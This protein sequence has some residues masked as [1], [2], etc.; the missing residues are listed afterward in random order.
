[1][2][3]RTS[4]EELGGIGK[5]YAKK[6]QNLGIEKVEDFIFYFP[7]RY[8]DY[9]NIANIVN[10]KPGEA[11]TLKGSVWQIVNRK[12]RNRR[13]IITE[14]VISDGTGTMKI[15][16]FNQP[17][18]KTSIK[19]GNEIVVAGKVELNFNQI[20]MTSPS[21]EKF[22]DDLKHSGRIVPVYPETEGVTSK[23]L[24]YQI[25][26]LLKLVYN[27]KDYLP[28]NVKEKY[29][30]ADLP[31]ALRA[32]HFP[33]NRLDLLEA[34]KRLGFDELFP[35]LLY[36]VKQKNGMTKEKA[37]PI[38]F[39]ET[40]AKEFV[41]SLPFALTNAQKKVSWEIVKDIKKDYPANRLVQGDVG[42][43]KTIV[44]A[45]AMY[46]AAEDG[47]QAIL[48]APTEIL[49]KQHF[50][51]LCKVF[52]PFNISVGLLTGKEAQISKQLT[53]NSKQ[54]R[55]KNGHPELVSGSHGIPGQARNDNMREKIKKQEFLEQV[56]SGEVDIL[57]GTHSLISS[58]V[59]F[60]NLSLAIVD[61]QHR[62]GVDQRQALRKASFRYPE[63][64]S[65]PVLDLIQESCLETGEILNQV[66]NEDSTSALPHFISMT[67]TPIPRSLQL[68]I[69][70]DLDVSVI[71]ELPPGRQKIATKIVEAKDRQLAYE[72]IE[73]QL[74]SGRQCFV[75]CPLIEESEKMD[76]KAATEEYKNLS[77]NIF[78]KFKVG[79]LHG[80][81]KTAEKEQIMNDFSSGNL[82]ILVS[83]SVIEVG[84]D[85]PNAAVMIIEGAE[86]FGLAQLHQFRGRVGR[87]A[88]KSY[89]FL[90]T[91]SNLSLDTATSKRLKMLE[92]SQDGFKLAE[93]DFEIRGPGE[94]LGKRQHGWSDFKIARFTD[95]KFIGKVR[96]AAEWY[97]SLDPEIKESPKLKER[98]E[99]INYAR[100]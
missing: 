23:W 47:L 18:L 19:V 70:G 2:N 10:A 31:N 9:S 77:E 51:S 26:P 35:I 75:I 38:N 91:N 68:T 14:A 52:K 59:Q 46:L 79:L 43:G 98:V 95:L 15:T 78:P 100:E 50:A 3:L 28:E 72:F 64:D 94:F 97:L 22:S 56:K 93:A 39:D 58:A 4:V 60:K 90:F 63:L 99:K 88:D 49:A 57:V 81:M 25:K 36:G 65:E 6:L 7:R 33:N 27:I 11:V 69:F 54:D 32:I 24:R 55:K 21:W 71:D 29:E 5:T 30:L 13:M 73:K 45:F 44:A 41:D 8:E 67:A 62:F 76:L 96:E 42:S 17:F 12:A 37:H 82:N 34:K 86:R 83:T 66:Q 74:L 53:V 92:Q 84:V 87:G 80:K 48:M 40:V 16:W 85:V 89:C 61:E 1:M 20:Q